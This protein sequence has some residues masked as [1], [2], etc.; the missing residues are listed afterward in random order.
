M[1]NKWSCTKLIGGG[2]TG[3]GHNL[4]LGRTQNITC[5]SLK[6]GAGVKNVTLNVL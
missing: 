1:K 5:T 2:H 3:G 4:I 6:I